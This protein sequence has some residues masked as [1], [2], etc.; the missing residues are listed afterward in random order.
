MIILKQTTESIL[1]SV[2]LSLLSLPQRHGKHGICL[3]KAWGIFSLQS[4][5]KTV[6]H[7]LFGSDKSGFKLSSTSAFTPFLYYLCVG[8][9]GDIMAQY[10]IHTCYNLHTS[11]TKHATYIARCHTIFF[12]SDCQMNS[13]RMKTSFVIDTVVKITITSFHI[14]RFGSLSFRGPRKCIHRRF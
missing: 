5:T 3:L 6:F 10:V 1:L 7:R 8:R 9:D 13:Q 12:L 2:S 4:V 11:S 14:S